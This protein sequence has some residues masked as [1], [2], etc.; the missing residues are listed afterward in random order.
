[1][2][3]E[4]LHREITS[5]FVDVV[6]LLVLL[7]ELTRARMLRKCLRGNT[8]QVPPSSFGRTTSPLGVSWCGA[9]QHKEGG[10]ELGKARGSSESTVMKLSTGVTNQKGD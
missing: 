9:L 10:L 6:R 1:M 4:I 7:V 5:I 3:M 8:T 2:I